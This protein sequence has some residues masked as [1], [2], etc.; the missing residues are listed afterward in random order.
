MWLYFELFCVILYVFYDRLRDLSFNV[1]CFEHKPGFPY[2]F[3]CHLSYEEDSSCTTKHGDVGERES[4]V[5][6]AG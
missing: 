3:I 4:V 5:L 6:V 2:N 1:W